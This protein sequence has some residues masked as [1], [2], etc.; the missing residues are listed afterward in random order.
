MGASGGCLGF[1]G[2][3]ALAALAALAGLAT[4]YAGLTAAAYAGLAAGLYAGLTVVQGLLASTARAAGD[5]AR[6]AGDVGGLDGPAPFLA[7]LLTLTIFRRGAAALGTTFIDIGDA[8]VRSMTGVDWGRLRAGVTRSTTGA[9]AS[10]RGVAESR[11]AASRRLP[12][13]PVSR[14]QLPVA[15]LHTC[16]GAHGGHWGMV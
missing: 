4:V 3:A 15:G 7:A 14:T 11:R 12:M 8:D 2:L 13:R 10:R 9:G 1:G 5:A 16:P 6:A